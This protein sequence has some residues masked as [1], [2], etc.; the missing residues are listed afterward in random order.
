MP[1]EL[2]R[3]RPHAR[4]M[5][6]TSRD[7]AANEID[8]ETGAPVAR[9]SHM[10]SFAPWLVA[11]A[12]AGFTIQQGS[13]DSASPDDVQQLKEADITRPTVAPVAPASEAVLPSGAAPKTE[14][15]EAQMPQQM[16]TKKPSATTIRRSPAKKPSSKD[17]EVDCHSIR[18]NTLTAERTGNWSTLFLLAGSPCWAN[19]LQALEW[20]VKAKTELQQ[21]DDCIKLGKGVPSPRIAR[22]VKLCETRALMEV[23]N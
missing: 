15:T 9:K 13:I 18:D 16:E 19:D 2:P 12:L 7:H 6:G 14:H 8:T 3:S 10:W 22:M 17:L 4:A 11:T 23:I 21:F 1:V 5:P 20:R